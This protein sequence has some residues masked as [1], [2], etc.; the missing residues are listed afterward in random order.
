LPGLDR[1]L[2]KPSFIFGALGCIAALR[3]AE[4]EECKE[5]G[6]DAG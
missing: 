6:K 5:G 1:A 4:G 3:L 2:G